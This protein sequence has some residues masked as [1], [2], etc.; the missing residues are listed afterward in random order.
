MNNY[1]IY[2]QGL[3]KNNFVIRKQKKLGGI[4]YDKRKI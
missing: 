1:L 4:N 2:Y 3:D